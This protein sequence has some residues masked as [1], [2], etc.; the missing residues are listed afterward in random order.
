VDLTA[1]DVQE[2]ARILQQVQAQRNRKQQQ[3]ARVAGSSSRGKGRATHGSK[4]TGNATGAAA[5][6]QRRLTDML[7]PDKGQPPAP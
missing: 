3:Q 5:A 2:Q 4:A 7:K 1:V 6:G